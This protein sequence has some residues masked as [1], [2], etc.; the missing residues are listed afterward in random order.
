M[1]VQDT[2]DAS[3]ALNV[4]RCFASYQSLNAVDYG[5]LADTYQQ[6]LDLSSEYRLAWSVDFVAGHIDIML[7]ARTLGWCDHSAQTFDR[8]SCDSCH[9]LS[10]HAHAASSFGRRVYLSLIHI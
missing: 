2:C 1:H 4:G 6:T 9:R 8:P 3:A 7:Q 5:P 10:L